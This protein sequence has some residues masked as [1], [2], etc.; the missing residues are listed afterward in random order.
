VEA[1]EV[2]PVLDVGGYSSI[3]EERAVSDEG[4]D[5]CPK[6]GI[7]R[8]A[9][10]AFPA[11]GWPN[12][13]PRPFPPALYTR[14]DVVGQPTGREAPGPRGEAVPD[15]RRAR[16]PRWRSERGDARAKTVHE[17]CRRAG[18]GAPQVGRARR[19]CPQTRGRPRGGGA[20]PQSPW[21][22]LAARR[23]GP[24]PRPGRSRRPQLA[25][26]GHD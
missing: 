14:A 13:G 16:A 21:D 3:Q 4:E 15:Q 5:G 23:P 25:Q 8:L 11:D 22:R 24:C 9:R 17:D 10:D 7:R 18:T 12:N 6:S 19:C 1:R 26:G 20:A 2:T